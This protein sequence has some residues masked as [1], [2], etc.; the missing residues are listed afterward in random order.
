[1]F[2]G[3][4]LGM[5]VGVGSPPT[6]E[7]AAAGGTTFRPSLLGQVLGARSSPV[8][9]TEGG[10]APPGRFAGHPSEGRLFQAR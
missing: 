2:V 4:F 10:V 8:L 9:C 3:V 6:L 7:A 5:D 1:M